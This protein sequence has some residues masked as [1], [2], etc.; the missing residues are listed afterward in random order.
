MLKDFSYRREKFDQQVHDDNIMLWMVVIITIIGVILA[1]LQLYTSYMLAMAGKV[2][3]SQD[4]SVTIEAGKIA[5]KSSITGLL[6]LA[7][8]FAFFCVFVVEVY[9]FKEDK[10]DYPK[11]AASSRDLGVQG[12]L[13]PIS[14]E[15]VDVKK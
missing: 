10:V 2:K 11:A 4:S 12:R 8:S 13:A 6:I 15:A 5:V 1:G 3:G 7:M 14:P 9:T